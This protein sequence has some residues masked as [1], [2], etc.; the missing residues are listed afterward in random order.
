[1]LTQ[2]SGM[3]ARIGGHDLQLRRKVDQI[4]YETRVAMSEAA[5][6]MADQAGEPPLASDPRAGA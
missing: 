4:V 2:M 3:A 1:M 6:Q 5:T